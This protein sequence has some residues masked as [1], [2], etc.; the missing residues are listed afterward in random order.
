MG[1]PGPAGPRNWAA[2]SPVQHPGQVQADQS[3][4]RRQCGHHGRGLQLKA[5][6]QL[7]APGA[8]GQQQA[9][10]GHERR[11]HPRRVGQATGQQAAAVVRMVG[12]TQHLE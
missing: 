7:L 11:H 3:E 9:G 2:P 8:Q 5:P 10:Q 12:K 1:V 4:Q 6:A